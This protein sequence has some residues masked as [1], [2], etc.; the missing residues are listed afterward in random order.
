MHPIVYFDIETTQLEKGGVADI[1]QLGAYVNEDINFEAYCLPSRNIGNAAQ[2]NGFQMRNGN[3]Y[4]YGEWVEANSIFNGL[5]RFVK[6]LEKFGEPVI[7]VAHNCFQFDAKV[8]FISNSLY[9]TE[10]DSSCII[11]FLCR[12]TFRRLVSINPIPNIKL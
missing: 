12:A 3:L 4:Q 8:I 7:L 11:F 10:S 1:I 9:P 5:C 2:I 6:W